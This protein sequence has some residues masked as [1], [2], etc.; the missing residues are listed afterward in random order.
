M[1]YDEVVEDEPISDEPPT[2][3]DVRKETQR[4]LL[5][6]T[7]K[8][9]PFTDPTSPEAVRFDELISN[10]NEKFALFEL[11]TSG[12]RE[13][14]DRE[15]ARLARMVDLIWVRVTGL[16]PPETEKD[17]ET[18]AQMAGPAASVARMFG[19]V[20]GLLVISIVA[21]LLNG[22]VLVAFAFRR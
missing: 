21:L 20:R 11:N 18:V 5:G 2:P 10:F 1:G 13:K 6:A 8:H 3:R 9:R 4:S 17:V 19:Y 14:T 22:A 12:A 16:K 7:A 15:I